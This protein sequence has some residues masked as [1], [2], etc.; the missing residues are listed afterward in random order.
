MGVAFSKSTLPFS[1][2][3]KQPEGLLRPLVS[4]LNL[5]RKCTLIERAGKLLSDGWGFSEK[6]THFHLFGQAMKGPLRPLV[7]YLNLVRRCNRTERA[8]KL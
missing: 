5:V 2:L 3:V 8:V 6:S 7:S 1:C 4:Y